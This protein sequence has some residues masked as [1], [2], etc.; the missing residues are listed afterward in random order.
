MLCS[1]LSA[2]HLAFAY[3]TPVPLVSN[4]TQRKQR[5][6]KEK[7]ENVGTKSKIRA[8]KKRTGEKKRKK[9]RI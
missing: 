3:V 9:K 5:A 7:K 2:F 1:V 8:E 4:R 6:K